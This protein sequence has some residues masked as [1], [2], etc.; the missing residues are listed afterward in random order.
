V[1]TRT[2]VPCRDGV[3]VYM[4]KFILAMTGTKILPRFYR[5]EPV[6]ERF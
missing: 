2:S 6:V 5:E 4:D 1:V 3:F